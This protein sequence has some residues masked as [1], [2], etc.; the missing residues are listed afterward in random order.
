MGLDMES[1]VED[2]EGNFLFDMYWRK[3]YGVH[4][5]MVEQIQDD[6][7][8]GKR[9][10][11]SYDK[12]LDL[13]HRCAAVLADNTLA[14]ELLP[15]NCSLNYGLGIYVDNDEYYLHSLVE[16]L[17]YLKK[18]I[19]TVTSGKEVTVYYESC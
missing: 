15:S 1:W 17:D 13:H 3:A 5:Y 8:D 10:V 4:T 11:V 2:K 18:I 7:D 9:Y 12:V 14:D 19:A 6:D 16:T